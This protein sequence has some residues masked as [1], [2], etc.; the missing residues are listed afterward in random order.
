MVLR[1]NIAKGTGDKFSSLMY[2]NIVQQ[3]ISYSATLEQRWDNLKKEL[4]DI[5]VLRE[6][7]LQSKR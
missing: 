2:S 6:K 1:E 7:Y 5:D 4:N 3:N